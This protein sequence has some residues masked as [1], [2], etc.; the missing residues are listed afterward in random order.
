MHFPAKFNDIVSCS[1]CYLDYSIYVLKT[2]KFADKDEIKQ[3]ISE[4]SES[5]KNDSH[6]MNRS[7][8]KVIHENLKPSLELASLFM[9]ATG[10]IYT[11]FLMSG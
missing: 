2:S 7:R 1:I 6:E 4:F 9:S 11:S 10:G 8:F 3:S 5:K